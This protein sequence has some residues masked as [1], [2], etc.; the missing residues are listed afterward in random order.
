MNAPPKHARGDTVASTQPSSVPISEIL[1]NLKLTWERSVKNAK[2]R[3]WK[4]KLGEMKSST[5]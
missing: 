3:H 5:V 4:K 1:D 2:Y